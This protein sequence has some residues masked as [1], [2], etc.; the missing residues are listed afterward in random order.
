MRKLIK[1][2]RVAQLI[3]LSIACLS[4]APTV[5]AQQFD[6]PEASVNDPAVFSRAMPELA[7]ALLA[8]YRD[9]DRQ[10]YLDNLF[11]LQIVAGQYA[12][13]IRTLTDLRALQANKASPQTGATNVQYEVFARAK[14]SA[15][16]AALDEALRRSF[17]EVMGALDDRTSALVMRGFDVDL[18]ALQ[19]TLTRALQQQKG[20][21]SISLADA[22]RLTRAYQVE[23]TYRSLAPLI[24]P[25]IIE[26]DQRRYIIER[27][28]PVKTADGATTCALIVRQRSARGRLP[29]LLN[30]TIYAYPTATLNEAR[31]SASNGY[32]GVEGLTRGKVCSPDRPVPYEHDGADA[33]ALIDWISRQ[34]W[35][36]GRVGMYGG[37]YDGFTQWA[38]AKHLP[39]ALKALMPSVTAAPG[40]DIPMDGGVFLSFTYPWTFY[41]TNGKTLDDKTYYDF[42]RWSRLS[43]EWYKSGRPYRELDKID[44]TPNPIFNRW[45]DHP[46]YDAYWQSM[47]PYRQEFARINIPVLTTTGYYDPGQIGA[48]YYFTQHYKYRPD[49]EHYLVVGPYDHITGQRGTVAPRGEIRNV[50]LGYEID[51]VAQIDL[52][53]LRYQWFDYNFKGGAKPALLKDKVNYE[54]MGANEWRYAPSI[55]AMGSETQRFH[56]SA[57]KQGDAY[58]LSE[59]RGATD[60]F[61]TQLVN[62]ADRDAFITQ[63]VNF[64]DR[65]DVDRVS[66]ST[67]N[68]SDKNLD[69]WNSIAFVSDPLAKPTELSGLFSGRI[70]FIANKKDLDFQFTLYEL[71]SGG[72]YFQ[73]SYYWARA[74]H[75]RDLTQ[76]HLLVPGQRQTLD[77][78]SGRLTSRKFQPGS[79][80][81]VLLSIIKQPTVQLNYGTGRDVSDETIADA[82]EPLKI[83]WFDGSFIDVPVRR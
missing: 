73:L 22:L 5:L 53:E 75:V 40:I 27:D 57:T 45:L 28:I 39:K 15:K 2:R 66:P 18:T 4:A 64:A 35:S 20:K 72:E 24:A 52:G 50:V 83:Q 3:V 47:I 81:V 1:G 58:R 78:K 12:D 23:E 59:Q 49:A 55:A 33:A 74:S 38:A 69:T 37:S 41:T 71:T 10:K 19:Q 14:Q 76:R 31:R 77:F 13:A 82:K 21:T 51:P 80:L 61:I 54:V 16:G 46:T 56:L 42:P 26:D 68:L 65:S 44:G 62:F 11:R 8:V 67:G 36:D 30:F 63:L 7:R 9:D 43:N 6:F 17:R 70:D 25:L 32:V 34:P 29:A 60:A 48:L 79:R